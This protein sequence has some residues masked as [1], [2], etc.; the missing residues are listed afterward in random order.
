MLRLIFWLFVFGLIFRVV[1]SYLLPLFR[2]TSVTNDHMR[3]MQD[4]MREMERK[5]NETKATP[6]PAAKK[7]NID[8]DYIDYEELK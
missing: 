7:A 1:F 8:G 4:Q 6:P 2:I 5:M 3:R